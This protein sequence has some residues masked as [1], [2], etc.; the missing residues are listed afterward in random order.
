MRLAPAPHHGD[1]VAA[2]RLGPPGAGS[3][4]TRTCCLWRCRWRT[5]PVARWCPFGLKHGMFG[6][7]GGVVS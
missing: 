3:E 6:G 4:L 1:A 5:P 2:S 7:E